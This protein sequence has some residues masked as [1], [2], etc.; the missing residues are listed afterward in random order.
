MS[1]PKAPK[2]KGDNPFDLSDVNAQIE[3]LD[4]SKEEFVMEEIDMDSIM[5][6]PNVELTE[7]GFSFPHS[8][9]F[10]AFSKLLSN[11]YH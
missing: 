3:A 11:S 7:D 4:P 1:R 10:Q 2:A 6:D 5:A 9:S 8:L